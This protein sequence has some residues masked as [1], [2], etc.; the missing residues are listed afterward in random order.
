[1]QQIKEHSNSIYYVQ[2]DTLIEFDLLSKNI[3]HHYVA[4]KEMEYHVLSNTLIGY[5]IGTEYF[6]KSTI[7]NNNTI[8]L[9]T[10]V[11]RAYIMQSP[12]NKKY[13]VIERSDRIFELYNLEYLVKTQQFKY[14]QYYP[15]RTMYRETFWSSNRGYEQ[16]DLSSDGK[17]ITWNYSMLMFHLDDNLNVNKTSITYDLAIYSTFC[18]IGSTRLVIVIGLDS[19]IINIHNL[20]TMCIKTHSKYFDTNH[21]I[22]LHLDSKNIKIYD[23]TQLTLVAQIEHDYKFIHYHKKLDTLITDSCELFVIS[24]DHKLK[25]ASIGLNYFNDIDVYPNMMMD[26]VTDPILLFALIPDDI[27]FCELYQQLLKHV[28]L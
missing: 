2:N 5:Q 7:N 10:Y 4:N 17:I 22:M 15:T 27:V 3:S 26:I 9:S 21:N 8:I 28:N 18:V 6:I 23:V 20:K 13:V 1:M 14:K 12:N 16:I 24:V 11:D 25:R 19:H